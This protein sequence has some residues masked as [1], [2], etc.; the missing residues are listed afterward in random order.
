M[1]STKYCLLF[2]FVETLDVLN[3][4]PFLI[5][6]PII[7][8]SSFTKVS[9]DNN[10]SAIAIVIRERPLMM[11]RR[12]SMI[13]D[14]PTMSDD[15]YLKTSDFWESFWT[16]LPQNRT[17]L[18]DVPGLKGVWNI[19][20][21]FW[22]VKNHK[23]SIPQRFKIPWFESSGIFQYNFFRFHIICPKL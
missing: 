4:L 22:S 16:H 13:F 20:Y 12:F 5:V 6:I 14:L 23:I 21:S 10:K 11:S 1:I 17:S 9:D 8:D 15:F 2:T 18:M 7:F 19:Q 3:R